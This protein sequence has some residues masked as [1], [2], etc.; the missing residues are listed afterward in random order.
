MRD[1]W[2]ECRGCRTR[3]N[4]ES[5]QF[6]CDE[7]S[8]MYCGSCHSKHEVSGYG[9]HN[10]KSCFE[11]PERERTPYLR[12]M[13][14]IPQTYKKRS[15]IERSDIDKTIAQNQVVSWQ[16]QIQNKEKYGYK[17]TVEEF[18]FATNR[19]EP[20]NGPPFC[21]INQSIY[22]KHDFKNLSEMIKHFLEQENDSEFSIQIEVLFD[23]DI[24]AKIH[25]LNFKM[26][27]DILLSNSFTIDNR[28][29]SDYHNVLRKA[30]THWKEKFYDDAQ[31]AYWFVEYNLI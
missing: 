23:D 28:R 24:L 27:Q 18:E 8:T 12:K 13:D 14:R 11:I 6:P 21:E 29:Y 31:V 7:C 15:Y 22:S 17:F 26:I 2:F 1:G 19:I 3:L 16:K 20:S 10:N 9:L 25:S 30:C 5:E 4:T